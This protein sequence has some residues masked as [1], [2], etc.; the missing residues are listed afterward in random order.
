M[1]SALAADSLSSL[2]QASA[3][4]MRSFSTS[5]SLGT[6]PVDGA[7]VEG[8]DALPRTGRSASVICSRAPMAKARS[9]NVL[10]LAHVARE[11]VPAERG[12]CVRRDALHVPPEAPG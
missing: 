3:R 6:D 5:A 9:M 11:I 2:W 4:R 12:Q 10:E 1:P 8:T 7:T